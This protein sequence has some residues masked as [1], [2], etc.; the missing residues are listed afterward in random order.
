MDL[1]DAVRARGG[2]DFIRQSVAVTLQALSRVGIRVVEGPGNRLWLLGVYVAAR[3][4][5]SDACYYGADWQHFPDE[6][7]DGTRVDG[8]SNTG[9]DGF[10]HLPK[11][12]VAG[13]NPVVRSV[14][15][16]NCQRTLVSGSWP[17]CS[18]HP[19]PVR[20]TQPGPWSPADREL[21]RLPSPVPVSV[22]SLMRLSEA[23]RQR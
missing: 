20:I 17:H 19:R 8:L 12:M 13:S 22:A 10:Q 18:L 14:W 7:M 1:L 5:R 16:A 11:V 21:L 6:E 9:R 23:G 15:R 4:T 2:V 3:P